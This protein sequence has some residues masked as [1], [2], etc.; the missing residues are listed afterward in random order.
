MPVA[1][2]LRPGTRTRDQGIVRSGFSVAR[3]SQDLAEVRAEIL[4]RRL[5][6][7]A[8]ADRDQQRLVR[9]E[10]QAPAWMSGARLVGY[11]AKNHAPVGEPVVLVARAPDRG[12]I[13]GL[14]TLDERQVHEAVGCEVRV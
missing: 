9:Q 8:I 13:G 5:V 7:E 1:P 4:C 2:D 6:L 14:V 11:H 3:E 12:A 10:Q